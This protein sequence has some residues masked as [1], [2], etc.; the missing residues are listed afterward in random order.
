MIQSP[1]SY[2]QWSSLLVWSCSVYSRTAPHRDVPVTGS[3]GEWPCPGGG[4]DGFPVGWPR[5]DGDQLVKLK[6]AMACGGCATIVSTPTR[7]Q[8]V[9]TNRSLGLD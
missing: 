2:L 1:C 7:T 4:G 6:L 5:A 3:A 9:P 8:W